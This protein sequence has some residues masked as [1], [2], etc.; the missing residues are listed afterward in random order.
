L[1]RLQRSFRVFFW[2]DANLLLLLEKESVRMRRTSILLSVVVLAAMILAACG[3]AATSTSA[4]TENVPPATT[5]VTA[6]SEATETS[7]AGSETATEAPTEATTTGIPGAPGIPVTGGTNSDRLSNQLHFTVF[8]QTG[9]QV[10]EVEDMILDL[11]KAKVLYVIV[12]AS[13]KRIPVPWAML[14]VGTSSNSANT[15]GQKNAFILQTDQDTFKNAP[16]LN[17]KNVPTLGQEPDSWDIAFRKYWEGG[18]AASSSNTPTGTAATDMTATPTSSSG[19]AGTG[20]GLATS[21][22]TS[23][24]GTSLAT[25][26]PATSAGS[27]QGTGT[28]QGAIAIQ[29]VQLASKVIDAQLTVGVQVLEFSTPAAGASSATSTPTAAGTGSATA[30]PGGAGGTGTTLATATSST[31]GTGLATATSTSASTGAAASTPSTSTTA[32]N[33][34]ATIDDLIVNTDSGNIMYI[35]VKTNSTDGEHLIPVPLNLLQLSGSGETSDQNQPSGN[36]QSFVLNIDATTLQ[37]A[38]SFQKDQFPDMTTAGWNSEFD[39]FWQNNGAGSGPGTGL[40]ATAT[41][42]P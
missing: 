41:P 15:N 35:V 28:V 22:P 2:D 42:S 30:T 39:S 38:P 24:T 6:T 33:L 25:S 11:S 40:Q 4:P 26:M 10:G 9:D 31:S 36:S 12:N 21:T 32:K 3:G 7:V 14:K 1:V 5:E 29:G 16:V 34:S 17:L 23:S 37:K 13:G 19:S 18:G 20:I 27:S 8:D